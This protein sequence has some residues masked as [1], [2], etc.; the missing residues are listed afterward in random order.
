K[1]WIAEFDG[2]CSVD[3]YIYSINSKLALAE[4]V[5]WFM[6]SPTYLKRSPVG[7]NTSQLPRI[8]LEEVAAVEFGL[9]SLEKQVQ[10]VS[11]IQ[12]VVDD[13]NQLSDALQERLMTIKAM[14]AA[15]LRRAF[16]GE[17]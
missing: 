2:L 1:V 7:S 17:L 15:V 12:C 16:N 13:I 9:P 8:R 4:Y 5:F 11:R 14:P 3:Q 6:L 10:V